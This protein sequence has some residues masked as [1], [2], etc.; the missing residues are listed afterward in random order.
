MTDDR[1]SVIIVADPQ[2]F[3]ALLPR[4][5]GQ[6]TSQ[7]ISQM[8][9]QMTR[10]NNVILQVPARKVGAAMPGAFAV[11]EAVIEVSSERTANG[12]SH[13]RRFAARWTKGTADGDA[14][15]DISPASKTS[16]Q[17]SV[18]LERPKGAAAAL[19]PRF[20]LRRLGRLLAKGLSY[21][22]ET[23]SIEEASPLGMRRTSPELVRARA[24]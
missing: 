11:G 3:K 16:T 21:E 8:T 4:R 7:V 23:R 13:A 9:S 24:S 20:A 22:I 19:W 1:R 6:M 14:T 18:T 10:G 12:G 15:I 17:I 5:R 2:S